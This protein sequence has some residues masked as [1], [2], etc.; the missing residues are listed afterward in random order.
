MLKCV[1]WIFTFFISTETKLL[2]RYHLQKVVEHNSAIFKFGFCGTDANNTA[3][4]K[5]TK[6]VS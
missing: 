6:H 3:M 4:D 2:F 5:I 1:Q